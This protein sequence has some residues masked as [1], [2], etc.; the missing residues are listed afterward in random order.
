LLKLSLMKTIFLSIT[1]VLIVFV[2]VWVTQ[3]SYESVEVRTFSEPITITQTT[4]IRTSF[5]KEG[6]GSVSGRD[7]SEVA[8]AVHLGPIK[9]GSEVSVKVMASNP[10]LV[11]VTDTGSAILFDL[12]GAY[13]EEYILASGL[14][15]DVDVKLLITEDGNYSVVIGKTAG[16]YGASFVVQATIVGLRETT[17]TTTTETMITTTIT[18]TR[19]LFS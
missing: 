16:N 1:L 9:A 6:H 10:V 14:G 2:I 8:E 19:K 17:I 18:T 4:F 15:T 11:L 5:T 3:Y 13:S 7:L 12:S